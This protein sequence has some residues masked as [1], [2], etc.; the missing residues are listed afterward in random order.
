MVTQGGADGSP[1]L[2]ERL[3]AQSRELLSSISDHLGDETGAV[4]VQPDDDAV[5]DS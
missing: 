5:A 4:A 2:T 1:E 3:L